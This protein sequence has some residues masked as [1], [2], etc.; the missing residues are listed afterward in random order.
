VVGQT[1][2]SVRYKS[3]KIFTQTENWVNRPLGFFTVVGGFRSTLSIL[4][5]LFGAAAAIALALGLA[6][7]P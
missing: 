4:A 1:W 3:D 6:A 7:K 5:V 2:P